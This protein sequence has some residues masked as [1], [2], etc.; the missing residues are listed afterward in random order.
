MV[1]LE[2]ACVCKIASGHCYID[3][4][5]FIAWSAHR[6]SRNGLNSINVL[7]TTTLLLLCLHFWH[8]VCLSD[9]LCC[10]NSLTP[11]ATAL[12]WG[13]T[14]ALNTAYRGSITEVYTAW[15]LMWTTLTC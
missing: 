14:T 2:E 8:V 3:S 9:L 5:Q 15:V 6:L 4:K 10:H 12:S 13:S 1:A 11:Y 7:P